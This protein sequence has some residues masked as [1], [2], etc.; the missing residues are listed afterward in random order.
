MLMNSGTNF[1]KTA[2]KIIT[3]K[4]CSLDLLVGKH[5][6]KPIVL[7][8]RHEELRVRRIDEFSSLLL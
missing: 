5:T 4:S 8:P 2:K 6:I 7:K 1:G 3:R